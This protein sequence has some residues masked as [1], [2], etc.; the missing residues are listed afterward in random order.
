MGKGRRGGSS[1]KE[2]SLLRIQVSL[3]YPSPSFGLTSCSL[4]DSEDS[5]EEPE[6]KEEVKET[7][8][9]K[10]KKN[11]KKK[12]EQE[13]EPEEAEEDADE[14]FLK[15]MIDKAK[16]EGK[17]AGYAMQ[18]GQSVLKVDKKLFN[19]QRELNSLFHNM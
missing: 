13:E 14:A 12:K 8:K 17:R 16:E 18:G 19:F 5:Q 7:K 4:S 15:S 10:K 3:A 1:Q 2:A 11:R 9:K 6:E